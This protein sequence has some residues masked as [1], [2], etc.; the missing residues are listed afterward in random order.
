MLTTKR[1][2]ADRRNVSTMRFP[3]LKRRIVGRMKQWNDGS[4]AHLLSG[5]ALSIELGK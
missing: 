5:K 3:I 1:R 4:I 2:L